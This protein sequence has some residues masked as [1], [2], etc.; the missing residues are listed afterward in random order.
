MDLRRCAALRLP[1]TMMSQGVV[2]GSL[3]GP[4]LPTS[5][6]EEGTPK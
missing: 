3:S 1:G 4:R 6:T 2:A 5:I